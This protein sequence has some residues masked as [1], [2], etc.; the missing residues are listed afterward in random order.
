M[1]ERLE[2]LADTFGVWKLPDDLQ[3]YECVPA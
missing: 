1:N 3:L 2:V